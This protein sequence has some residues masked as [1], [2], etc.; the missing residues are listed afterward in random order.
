MLHRYP[1]RNASFW[2]ITDAAA[3]HKKTE[4]PFRPYGTGLMTPAIAVRIQ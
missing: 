3:I 1:G 4:P 2:V